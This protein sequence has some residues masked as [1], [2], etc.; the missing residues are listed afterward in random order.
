[1]SGKEECAGCVKT[2][3]EISSSDADNASCIC[4]CFFHLQ[5][6]PY[7]KFQSSQKIKFSID[8]T[9]NSF[10]EMMMLCC[11]LYCWFVVMWDRDEVFVLIGV[12]RTF[13]KYHQRLDPDCCCLITVQGQ[14]QWPVTGVWLLTLRQNIITGDSN[15][16][17]Q[18]FQGMSLSS[19]W[20]L[21]QSL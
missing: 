19:A 4:Q 7:N 11:S 9:L 21:W 14:R 20:S 16:A 12:I 15:R 13:Y 18:S 10:S 5:N 17:R 1:M 3:Q 2:E 8:H 6:M